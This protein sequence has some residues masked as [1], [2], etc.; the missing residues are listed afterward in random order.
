MHEAV[1]PGEGPQDGAPDPVDGVGH[2]PGAVRGVE[3][4][5]RLHQ[6]EVPFADQVLERQAEF[7]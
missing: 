5:R 3:Q 4:T 1:M 6:A 7:R 2:E